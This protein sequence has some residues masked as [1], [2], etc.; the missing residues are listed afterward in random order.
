[1]GA[2]DIDAAT[3][4]GIISETEALLQ[5]N[6]TVAAEVQKFVGTI[7]AA[8]AD[9]PALA[10]FSHY[11]REMLLPD[12][13]ALATRSANA[14]LATRRAL[15][16][17]AA[18]DYEMV[19]TAQQ[20]AASL[21]I[22]TPPPGAGPG[23]PAPSAEPSPDSAPAAHIPAPATPLHPMP[24]PIP[25]LGNADPDADKVRPAK[26]LLLTIDIGPEKTPGEKMRFAKNLLLHVE[27][28]KPRYEPGERLPFAR[29][30]ILYMDKW[31][32]KWGP[33]FPDPS[34]YRTLPG[35]IELDPPQVGIPIP[36]TGNPEPK[37]GG[38]P[39][40]MADN[41]LLRI[42][43]DEL[44]DLKDRRFPDPPVY[45]TLP[46]IIELDP[47]QVGIPIPETGNP[48]PK[49]GGNP[50]PMADNW[51][52][53]IPED[54]LRDL[55]DRRFPDPP[56]AT[57]LPDFRPAPDVGFPEDPP[58]Y[59]TLPGVFEPPLPVLPNP[60]LSVTVPPIGGDT[61]GPAP[62]VNEEIPVVELFSRADEVPT[63]S[64]PSPAPRGR[65]GLT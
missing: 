56:F 62:V 3:A 18:G 30:L 39:P 19:A 45:R 25:E 16:E 41:W 10:S 13:D 48:E 55:K 40:P 11:A 65:W 49:A 21:G 50:P 57:P 58:V 20:A 63:E 38:N 36:E 44:R 64:A 51:L 28:I 46:G 12:I 34:V 54:E 26:N 23:G 1:M 5:P 8:L 37:A 14:I 27:Y 2:Y 35:I 33:G 32:N 24:A 22:L 42:P 59:R 29:S 53:R 4:G 52:L 9:S 31:G 43:E 47:P 61:P 7:E 60:D 6:E 17:Y 15:S